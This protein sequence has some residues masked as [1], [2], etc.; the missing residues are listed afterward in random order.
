MLTSV[1]LSNFAI[2]TELHLDIK[3]GMT[4]ITGETGA[5]KSI[6]VD[7]LELLSGKRAD[8]GFIKEGKESSSITAVFDIS[9]HNEA[10]LWLCDHGYQS[11]GQCILRRQLPLK[12]SS[13][14]FINGSPATL[15]ELRDI[16]SLILDICGQH[17][18][19]NLLNES[20]QLDQVDKTL[21]DTSLIKSIASAYSDFK[22]TESHLSE[23]RKRKQSDS[24][25]LQLLTYQISELESLDLIDGEVEKLETD[26]SELENHEHITDCLGGALEQLSGHSGAGALTSLQQAL[27]QVESSQ[28]GHKLTSEAIEM[29]NTAIINVDESIGNI[30]KVLDSSSFDNQRLSEIS[31]RLTDIYKAA[32][33]HIVAPNALIDHLKCLEMEAK[34]YSSID[35]QISDCEKKLVEKTESYQKIANQLSEARRKSSKELSSAVNKHLKMLNLEKAKFDINVSDSAMSARGSNAIS[36]QFSANVGQQMRPLKM[37][38]SGGEMSRVSLALQ[39]S[40]AQFSKLPCLIFDEVDEGIGGKTSVSVGKLLRNL[41]LNNQVIVITHQAQ[42]AALSNNHIVVSKVHGKHETITSAKDM[43]AKDRVEEVARM[44]GGEI[45]TE[46]TRDHAKELMSA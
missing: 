24:D 3:P 32:K 16:S 44:I 25:R 22:T 13:K 31:S 36:Y 21:S 9:E 28:S 7:A 14:A 46:T 35:D 2:A 33:K 37:V 45:I 30:T 1:H 40:M 17:A 29:I 42:V 20:K 18:H 19:I 11:E 38:A 15:N 43:S 6:M 10:R 27:K 23:L 4:A 39:I 41:G 34:N 12:G 8:V 26:L 5:G